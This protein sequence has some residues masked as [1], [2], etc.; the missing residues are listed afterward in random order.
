[1][2][3]NVHNG[4]GL[5][6]KA[7]RQLETSSFEGLVNG[8]TVYGNQETTAQKESALKGTVA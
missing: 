5:W 6:P 4:R 8:T 7:V 2:A 3:F 1:L